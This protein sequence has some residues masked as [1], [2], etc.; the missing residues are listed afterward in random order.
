MSIR[1]ALVDDQEL[2]RTGLAMVIDACDDMRVVAQAG[3]GAQALDELSRHTADI[4]LMDVQMPRMNGVDATALITARDDGP[5]VIV[6]TTFDLD[7]Y[8]YAALRAGASGFLLKDASHDQLATAIRTVSAGQALLAPPITRR[9]V[10]DFCR[11]PAPDGAAAETAQLSQRELDV[12]R[13]VAQGLSNAEI[14][15]QLYLSDSTV[16]SHIARILAKLGL[17]DR[18]Q[19][20]VFA[21]ETGIIRPGQ[22]SRAQDGKP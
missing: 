17:R 18:V 8:A 5:K 4:V 3:D 22:S 10:E 13:Q 6:L 16:K 11:G 1:V 21:Y 7:D 19:I 15:G 20:V 2:V 14:A 9:L 12:V